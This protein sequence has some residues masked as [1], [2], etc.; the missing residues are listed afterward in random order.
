MDMTTQKLKKLTSI[1]LLFVGMQGAQAGVLIDDFTDYQ[2]AINGTDGPM[3]IVG[4]D[5]PNLLRTLTAT[6]SPGSGETEVIVENG[7]LHI[8]N[9]SDSSGTVSVFYSFNAIDLT[10]VAEGFLFDID[11]INR[12]HEVQVIANATSLFDFV[13]FGGA[14]QYE[15]AFSQFTDPSV[16]AQLTSLELN[17]RGV[18]S[19]D[20]RF[21][22]LATDSK[23]V[24]EPSV[25]VLLALGFM[26]MSKIGNR[27]TSNQSGKL[28]T[29]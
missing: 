9:D 11:F 23:Q 1:F 20:A 4:T 15:I 27:K 13:N 6:A 19:W 24:P 18:K 3:N 22:L 8:S 17:F 16:F 21:G 5:L 10:S 26:V 14:G 29:F 7:L 2:E 28:T 12:S 25:I